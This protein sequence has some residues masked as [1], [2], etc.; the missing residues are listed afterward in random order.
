LCSKKEKNKMNKCPICKQEEIRVI[1]KYRGNS[2]MFANRIISHCLKCDFVFASPMP[3]EKEL[4]QYNSQYFLNAHGGNATH[5]I[6]LAFHSAIN[7]IRAVHALEY[8]QKKN[9]SVNRVLEIG[10]GLGYLMDYF[11]NSNPNIEYSIVESD[12]ENLENL[13]K[14]ATSYYTNVNDIPNGYFDLIVLSHVLEHTIDPNA[15]LAELFE[16]VSKKGLIFIEV[17]NEDYKFKDLDEPHLL[18]FNILSM[19]NLLEHLN[20]FDYDIT[21]HGPP[22]S[23]NFLQKFYRKLYQFLDHKLF[24]IKILI[25]LYLFYPKMRT[26]LSDREI[27]SILPFDAVTKKQ[28]ASWWL[29]AVAQKK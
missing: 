8:A 24:K 23:G 4:E 19:K 13:K 6:A 3:T 7:K 1:R 25:P 22:I 29:R 5:P 27:I 15:F 16:K 14:K 11:L 17:P 21:L 2:N 12:K 20:I 26:Y 18:F 10:P 28:N 9:K